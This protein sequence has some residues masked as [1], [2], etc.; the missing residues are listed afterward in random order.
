MRKKKRIPNSVFALGIAGI[1]G[2]VAYNMLGSK[3]APA[4]ITKERVEYKPAPTTDILV[5][6]AEIQVGKRLT[7]SDF[8][9]RPWPNELLNSSFI[10]RDENQ[11]RLMELVNTVTKTSLSSGEPITYP[12]VFKLG[13]RSTMAGLL[14]DGMRAVAIRIDPEI[15]AGGFVKPGDYVDI[16]LTLGL[17]PQ[18]EDIVSALGLAMGPQ[19]LLQGEVT[20]AK[21]E[22]EPKIPEDKTIAKHLPS[23]EFYKKLNAQ[24]ELFVGG[25]R[26]YSEILLE[27]V[28]VLGIDKNTST[29]AETPDGGIG[30]GSGAT[31]TLEVTSEQAKLLAWASRVGSMKMALRSIAESSVSDGENSLDQIPRTRSSFALKLKRIFQSVEN[32]RGNASQESFG[33]T[34]PGGIMLLRSGSRS[35]IFA[36]MTVQARDQGER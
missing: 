7:K 35:Q 3:S 9:W 14:R 17:N 6:T 13:D 1:I 28:R 20:E 34:D 19:R 27:N 21:E 26:T 8:A 11:D 24:D 4:V 2:L 25:A 10:L 30:S 36:P 16:I 31:A 18:Q 23:E 5:A 12:K 22:V 29:E 33:V 32:T 15:S